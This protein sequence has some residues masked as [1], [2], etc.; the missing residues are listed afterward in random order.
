[1]VVSVLKF[2]FEVY[3]QLNSIS[4][5]LVILDSRYDNLGSCFTLFALEFL[6]HLIKFYYILFFFCVVS[7]CDILWHFNFTSCMKMD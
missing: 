2:W 3:T 6:C 4:V 5:L 7:W 1:M